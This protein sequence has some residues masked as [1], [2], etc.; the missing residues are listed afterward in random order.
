MVIAS[1]FQSLGKAAQA[2]IIITTKQFLLLIPAIYI[3]PKFFGLY[4]VWLAMPVADS[5]SISIA[6]IFMLCEI[7][8]FNRKAAGEAL[9][10]S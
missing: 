10:S 9:G 8:I 6:V 7:R 5:L 2:L 4:G 3:L 1:F